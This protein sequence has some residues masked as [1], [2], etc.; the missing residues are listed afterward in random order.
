MSSLDREFQLLL[1]RKLA[2]TYPG[3]VSPRQLD[4]QQTDAKLTFNAAYL[5]EHGLIAAKVIA[6][7]TDGAAN[8]LLAGITARGLDFLEDDGGLSAILGVVTVKFEA[9]SLRALIGAHIEADKS[10]PPQ[11]KAR[12]AGW[13][14]T[15][16]TEALKEATKSLV[17]AALKH[18]PDALQQL[19]RQLG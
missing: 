6:N 9:E 16:G 11:E 19:G 15:A 17:A 14:K 7:S 4:M 10:L 2:A 5:A 3:Q 1:L 12:L 13:L 8:L 18:W